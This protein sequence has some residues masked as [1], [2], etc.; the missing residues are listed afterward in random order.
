[1]TAPDENRPKNL[2]IVQAKK[3]CLL[4][5]IITGLFPLFMTLMLIVGFILPIDEVPDSES[6]SAGPVVN[7]MLAPGAANEILGM[8]S[9]I[10]KEP[11]YLVLLSALTDI[12]LMVLAAIPGGAMLLYPKWKQYAP[13]IIPF[14][15]YR[16]TEDWLNPI[17]IHWIC[18]LLSFCFIIYDGELVLFS[19]YGM[20]ALLSTCLVAMRFFW[21]TLRNLRRLEKDLGTMDTLREADTTSQDTVCTSSKGLQPYR[22]PGVTAVTKSHG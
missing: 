19:A 13:P 4:G 16:N 12:G 5:L 14:N 3:F 1:M 9:T 2:S 7:D 10:D 21:I 18:A 8:A 15:G 17:T 22:I 20:L 6:L 11:F